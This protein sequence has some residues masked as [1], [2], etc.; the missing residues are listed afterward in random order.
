MLSRRDLISSP[1][2]KAIADGDDLL[3]T[4][5]FEADEENSSVIANASCRTRSIAVVISEK[6]K[7]IPTKSIEDETK[8]G[9][10]FSKQSLKVKKL[11]KRVRKLPRTIR[12]NSFLFKSSSNTVA[13]YEEMFEDRFGLEEEENYE[14]DAE[15]I[16]SLRSSR[17]NVR[18]GMSMLVRQKA[19]VM[20]RP[21]TAF[22]SREILQS[23]SPD[24]KNFRAMMLRG[25]S[26][27]LDDSSITS[28]MSDI[29]EDASAVFAY[30]NT[31]HL[32]F[33]RTPMFINANTYRINE[34]EDESES[35]VDETD[36]P[37]SQQD[38][39]IDRAYDFRELSPLNDGV[40][41]IEEASHTSDETETRSNAYDQMRRRIY[42]DS[43]NVA[44]DA[45]ERNLS[46]LT[47]SMSPKNQNSL[48]SDHP[49]SSNSSPPHNVEPKGVDRT[50]G[51]TPLRK[52]PFPRTRTRTHSDS[53]VAEE[54]AK[55][56]K[57]QKSPHLDIGLSK[58]RSMSQ[59]QLISDAILTTRQYSRRQSLPNFQSNGK[60]PNKPDLRTR[61]YSDSIVNDKLVQEDILW[62]PRNISLLDIES[63]AKD[64]FHNSATRPLLLGKE[65]KASSPETP[66][67]SVLATLSNTNTKTP[68]TL[69]KQQSQ[70]PLMPSPSPRTLTAASKIAA[71]LRPTPEKHVAAIPSP[72]A[73][74]SS[75]DQYYWG[76]EEGID[77]TEDQHLEL[78]NLCS[79]SSDSL[80]DIF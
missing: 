53:Y 77:V 23:P 72:S 60:S 25:K 76:K 32:S 54:K 9:L 48:Q 18:T 12:Q 55:H 70:R 1:A 41:S 37:S 7:M 15:T 36:I 8:G 52:W 19:L 69:Q 58:Q 2:N 65:L 34:D 63:V 29:T 40:Q 39:A 47:Q 71:A 42:S 17:N 11:L 79:W 13:E 57:I 44:S 16:A 24:P 61:T 75:S 38:A 80:D 45:Y 66:T 46:S 67:T 51:A 22:S 64:D 50:T 31:D 73:R 28:G 6:T 27:V 3:M 20:N 14:L 56:N 4:P 43:E 49:K 26:L 74:Q 59:E 5:S 35:D 30:P 33:R 10:Q 68:E 62:D 78:K 21:S